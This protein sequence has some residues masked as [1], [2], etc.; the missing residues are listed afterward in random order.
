MS[1]STRI[2]LVAAAIGLAAAGAATQSSAQASG[3]NCTSPP[4]MNYMICNG[5]R[6]PK[7]TSKV[8]NSDGSWREETRQGK[9]VVLK[10]KTASGEYKE[11]RRCD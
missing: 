3:Q 7:P 11:V 4:G 2:T 8:V 5:R 9:C 6:V 1:P 10:E